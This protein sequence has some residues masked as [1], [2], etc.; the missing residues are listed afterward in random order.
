MAMWRPRMN[1]VNCHLTLRNK[2]GMDAK[3]AQDATT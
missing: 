2:A 3:Q 1:K